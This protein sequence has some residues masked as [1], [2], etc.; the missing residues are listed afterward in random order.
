MFG[1]QIT[2]LGIIPARGGSK[3]IPGKNIAMVA[4]KPLIAYTIQAALDAKSLGRVVVS[5][6]SEEIAEVARSFGAETPF[7]RPPELAQD[8][9][10]GIE[11][12]IHAVRWLDEHESYRPD[13]VMVLQP[14]SPLR[15]T[16]D[17]E[18]A[19]QLARERQADSV[20]SVCT[21]QQHPYW[22]KRVT[23][24]GKLVDFLQTD[25]AYTSRQSLPSVYA[26]N[27][28]I[29]LA[30]REILLERKT[31]YTDRTYAYIMPEERS[32]DVDIKLDLKLAELLIRER[33]CGQTR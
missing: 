22:M 31:F 25:K 19:V 6:D 33:A 15:A 28:A 2:V 11:P 20:V 27:G 16:E 3:S 29:Y 10:P 9:T 30:R 14:T 21:A 18:A 32:L 5:T 23:K 17:I 4:G 13:Y 1:G 26:L 12:V 24:D 7:L 8:D